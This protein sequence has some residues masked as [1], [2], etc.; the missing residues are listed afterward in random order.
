M[1]YAHACRAVALLAFGRPDRALE[2]ADRAVSLDPDL[3]AA[4]EARAEALAVLGRDEEADA[5][6]GIAGGAV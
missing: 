6:S 3:G 4:H 2:A 1:A 5:E